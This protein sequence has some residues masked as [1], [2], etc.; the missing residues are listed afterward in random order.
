MLFVTHNQALMFDRL[1][2]ICVIISAITTVVFIEGLGS[3]PTWLFT[4][5]GS[6]IA[7]ILVLKC[8]ADMF[9]MSRPDENCWAFGR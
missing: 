6:F 9:T 2:R 1:E 5:V 7:Q 8:W 3:N 4:S